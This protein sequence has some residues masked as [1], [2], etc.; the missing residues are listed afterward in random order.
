MGK[1]RDAWLLIQKQIAHTKQ[2]RELFELIDECVLTYEDIV[3]GDSTFD[4]L[5]A[6]SPEDLM[7]AQ[8]YTERTLED[9]DD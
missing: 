9:E 1:Y 8:E 6:I 5:G 4:I 7:E 2:N 3:E